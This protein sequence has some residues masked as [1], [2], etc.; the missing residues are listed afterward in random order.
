VSAASAVVKAAPK[1]SCY[2]E[3]LPSAA[4]VLAGLCRVPLFLMA[5]K[6]GSGVLL[7]HQISKCSVLR[8]FGKRYFVTNLSCWIC[9]SQPD[10][11]EASE[12]FG[13]QTKS[14]F[15][16]FASHCVFAWDTCAA[17]APLAHALSCLCSPPGT[18]VPQVPTL[19]SSHLAFA[20][21]SLLVSPYLDVR[22]ADVCF[23]ASSHSLPCVASLAWGEPCEYIE[24]M[25]TR[26]SPV[27]SCSWWTRLCRTTTTSSSG[28]AYVDPKFTAL[29]RHPIFDPRAPAL[30]FVSRPA[31]PFVE[32]Q[33]YCLRILW[34]QEGFL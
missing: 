8:I 13:W 32:H 11:A 14:S 3:Q 17:A 6:T 2:H 31:H 33:N 26:S 9:S 27:F 28:S 7:S 34:C 5:L 25:L 16:C 10:Q 15:A 1:E 18:V 23:F 12:A 24:H 4:Q 30:F 21:G 22:D 29:S 20:T 19:G